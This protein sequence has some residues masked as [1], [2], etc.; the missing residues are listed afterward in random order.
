MP[1][2]IE[3]PSIIEAAGTKPKRIE[4]YAGR[5]NS[6]HS[7]VSVARMKS[8]EGWVEPGQRPEFEEITVVLAGMLRVE[9]E[10]GALDVRAG[11]AVVTR[12]GEWIRYSTPEA[13]GAEYVAVC[14]PAFSPDTVHRDPE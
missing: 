7:A 14:L 2:L 9:H 3:A 1:T 13:G 4:E 8:P 12:A 11:Q 10:G 6:G 5:V